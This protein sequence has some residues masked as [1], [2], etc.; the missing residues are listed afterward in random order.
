[1]K[2]SNSVTKLFKS[3]TEIPF[4]SKSKF[5]F[6]SDCHRGDNGW[7]DDFAPNENI[8]LHALKQYDEQGFTYFELGDGDELWENKKFPEIFQ[9]HKEVY[10]LMSKM[11]KANRLHLIHGNHDIEWKNEEKISE[12]LFHYFADKEKKK[13]PLFNDIKISEGLKLKS[14]EN[15]L[16]IF[17][18][19]GHQVDWVSCKIWWFSRFVVRKFW[20][21]LQK[22]GFNNPTSPAK[23]YKRREKVE[24]KLIEWVDENKH[25]MIAG[26]THRPVFPTNNQPPYFNSGSCVHPR[27]ISGIE[28]VHGGITMIKWEVAPDDNGVLKIKKNIMEGPRQLTEFLSLN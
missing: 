15:D 22:M 20:K 1:M 4:D 16:T 18:L 14:K 2:S 19:H 13:K 28:I 23:N 8:F 5:V 25:I 10:L 6:F 24:K 17:L 27:C 21:H 26:H 12:S 3:S 11:F 9:A 7:A